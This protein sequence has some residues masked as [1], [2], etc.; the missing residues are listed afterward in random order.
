MKTSLTYYL[1]SSKYKRL[2]KILVGVVFGLGL[3]STSAVADM[4]GEPGTMYAPTTPGAAGSDTENLGRA[5]SFGISNQ[6]TWIPTAGCTPYDSSTTYMYDGGGYRYLTAGTFLDCPINLPSGANLILVRMYY[7]DNSTLNPGLAVF[8]FEQGGN[9]TNIATTTAATGT[10]GY[11]SNSVNTNETIQN[12]TNTYIARAILGVDGTNLSFMGFRLYWSRQIAPAPGTA[13][14]GDVSTGH[15]FFQHIEA[16]SASG[17]TGGC[18]GGNFCPDDPLTR[19]QMAVFLA[20]ALGLH[21]P[22]PSY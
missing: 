5:G 14:F 1:H 22:Y 12:G 9:F 20:K 13:T 15:P 18:G 4:S 8:R 10:P 19:G 3:G 2:A 21:W 6:A 7:K 17:I 11:T 16:L